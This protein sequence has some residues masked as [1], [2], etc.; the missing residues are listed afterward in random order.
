MSTAALKRE[1]ALL[2]SSL[3]ALTPT[4]SATLDDH[5]AWAERT[6]GLTFDPWQRDVLLSAAPRLLLNAT[7]QSGKSTV[8]AL[9]AARTVLEG[10]LA[11]VVSPSLRQSGFLFR[12]LARHLVASDAAFRHVRGK[13]ADPHGVALAYI[14]IDHGHLATRL[15]GR[16]HAAAGAPLQ[17]LDRLHVVRMPVRDDDLG[18]TARSGSKPLRSYVAAARP[19][20]VL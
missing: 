20:D 16:D 14:G 4:Q 19:Q 1:L 9:K 18:E 3:A 7:R 5:V 2:R 6:A 11:V 13:L 17:G 10:G 12:K 8:A 15:F